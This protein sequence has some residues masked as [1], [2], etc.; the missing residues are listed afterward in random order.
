[1]ERVPTLHSVGAL[2]LHFRTLFGLLHLS[3]KEDAPKF[4]DMD[5]WDLVGGDPDPSRLL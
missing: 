5:C 4:S 2:F 1:M 3:H